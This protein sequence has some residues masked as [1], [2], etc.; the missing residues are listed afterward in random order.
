[1]ELLLVYGKLCYNSVYM[2]L[3]IISVI[4]VLLRTTGILHIPYKWALAPIWITLVMILGSLAALTLF[5]E[6]LILLLTRAYN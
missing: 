3:F 6:F 4:L 2:D 5:P 1:M